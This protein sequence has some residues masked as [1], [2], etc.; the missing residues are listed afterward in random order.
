MARFERHLF[1]CVNERSAE[2]P[3]GCCQA[4]G[5]VGLLSYLKKRVHEAGLKGRVRVNKAGCLDACAQGP[6]LV[7]YP[8]QVWYTPQSEADMEEIFIEHV[9]NGRIVDR[10]RMAFTPP[11]K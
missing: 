7:V 4:R 5:S 3:R 8:E 11:R 6:S 10:L 2:D 9:Q 1:M